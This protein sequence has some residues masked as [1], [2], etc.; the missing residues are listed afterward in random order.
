MNDY[1][2]RFSLEG[3]RAVVTGASKGIGA[4]IAGLLAEAGAAVAVVGRDRAGLAQTA[5]KVAAAG[6]DC[7]PIEADLTT[8]DGP[9]RA[10]AAALERFGTVD[11]LVNNAG[12]ARIAPLLETTVG[13]WEETLCGQ[14]AGASA[15]GPSVGARHDPAAPGQDHQS[16]FTG[17]GGG[18]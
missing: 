18:H 4:E 13:D 7:L 12:I 8:V 10:A 6:Q 11:I 3:K 1:I 2:K 9:R 17:R 16:L 15:A 5:A 14:P